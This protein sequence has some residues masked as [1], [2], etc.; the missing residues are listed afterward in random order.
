MGESICNGFP[1]APP[2]VKQSIAQF[3][4]KTMGCLCGLYTKCQ[5]TSYPQPPH[6]SRYVG[7]GDMSTKRMSGPGTS[8]VSE[9]W[10]SGW[11]HIDQ[12][13]K[14]RVCQNC[15]LVYPC[16]IEKRKLLP[17]S[18]LMFRSTWMSGSKGQMWKRNQR[19]GV[20]HKGGAG[21]STPFGGCTL[22]WSYLQGSRPDKGDSARNLFLN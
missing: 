5:H 22:P 10:S 21:T 14:N 15:A 6:R 3:L 17:C 16:R 9:L 19:N 13:I 18:W 2:Q 20:S 8:K 4:L 12:K 11:I 7:C 1:A